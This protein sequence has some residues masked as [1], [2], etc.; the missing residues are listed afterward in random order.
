MIEKVMDKLKTEDKQLKLVADRLIKQCE[1]E[2]IFVEKILNKNKSLKD[3]WEYI[4]SLARKEAKNGCAVIDDETVYGW[5]IHYFDENE[6]T[7]W[8][9]FSQKAK[10]EEERKQTNN[11]FKEDKKSKMVE[12]KEV[13]EDDESDD[14]DFEEEIKPVKVA[15]KLVEVPKKE[16]PVKKPKGIPDGQISLF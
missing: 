14:E 15:T 6:L 13:L 5:A 16:I 9:S 10:E 8:K 4:K 11:K 7:D 3:C 2:S 1:T 12:S